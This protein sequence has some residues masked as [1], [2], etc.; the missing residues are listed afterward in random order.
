MN[1]AAASSIE[2]RSQTKSCSRDWILLPLI[3]L[4]TIAILAI[5]TECTLRLL[6]PVAQVGFDN[7]FVKNDALAPAKPNS[8]CFERFAESRF[9]AEYRFD[10]RGHR[11]NMELQP[12]RP[13]SYRIVMI[14]SSMAMGL[15]VPQQMSFASTLPKELS[16]RTRRRVEL[17]N[18]ATG[19]KYRGGPFPIHGSVGRFNAVLSANPDMILWVVTPMDIE[20]ADSADESAATNLSISTSVPAEEPG[21]PASLWSKLRNAIANGSLRDKL[22]DRWEQSRTAVILKHFLLANESSGEYVKS[23]LENDNEA[24]FLRAQPNS[25]WQHL[26]SVFQ[27]DA[28]E[29]AQ[30]AK[31][32]GVPFVVVLIPNRAQAA[33]VSMGRWPEGYDPYK[34]DNELR[35]MVQANGGI[36]MDILPNFR[37][38]PSPERYYFPLDGHLDA[39]GHALVSGQLTHNLTG[40]VVS[41]LKAEP[42]AQIVSAQDR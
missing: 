2:N 8:S 23:F 22:R 3:S 18:E 30:R 11:S 39:D 40:G 15:F 34:L 4:L 24:G 37:R 31:R 20:N 14:G 5:S 28:A 25:K 27:N 33:M 1:V 16:Y 19:G 38:I 17:Y 10:S 21:R 35:E 36:Y 26:L 13:D 32:A 12:K 41:A 9:P 42:H 29:F 7:C 6:F